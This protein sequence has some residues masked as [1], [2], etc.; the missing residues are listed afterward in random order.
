M[1]Y[2]KIEK[3]LYKKFILTLIL[4]FSF[5]SFSVANDIREFEVEGISIGD[6]LLNFFSKNE[7]DKTGSLLYPNKDMKAATFISQDFK[8][9][10]EIQF[11]WLT[12]DNKYIIQ[13]IS[14]NLHYKNNIKDC[15][16][17]REVINN[18]IKSLFNN[19]DEDD[20]GKRVLNNVDPSLQ[21]FAYQNIYW[22][23]GGNIII[24]CRDYGEIKEK[25]RFVDYLSIMIDSKLFADW[26][27]TKAWD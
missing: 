11:H 18:E 23:D 24:S 13:S 5:Q 7:I 4:V 10:Q 25:N 17:Q 14:A 16:K 3:K 19:P 15:L 21:T 22:L 9:F 26:I 2:F 20:W 27:N 12:N 6:S 8:N 1:N